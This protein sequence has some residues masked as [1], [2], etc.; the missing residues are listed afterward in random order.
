[1][2]KTASPIIIGSPTL[3]ITLYVERRTYPDCTDYCDGNWLVTKVDLVTRGFRGR[4]EENLRA[5]ELAMFREELR[6]LYQSLTGRAKLHTM[7]SWIELE[8][9]SGQTGH[10][11]VD[12]FLMDEVGIGNRL[13]FSF[14]LDRSYLPDVLASLEQTTAAYP[15]LGRNS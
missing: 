4:V 1:V 12:G 2:T 5:E 6:T 13:N 10:I 14:D 11:R 9:I 7:E 8:F 15:V 3:G